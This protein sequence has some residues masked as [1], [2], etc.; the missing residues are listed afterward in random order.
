[1]VEHTAHNGKNVGSIPTVPKKD[2]ILIYYLL[3]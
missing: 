3:C 2:L 1:M